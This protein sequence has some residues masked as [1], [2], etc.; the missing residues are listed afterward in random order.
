M[1]QDLIP[2]ASLPFYRSMLERSGFEADI[3]AFDAG[4]AAGDPEQAKAGLSDALLDSLA[5]I[6]DA[7]RV[8][9]AVERYRD[10]GADQPMRGRHPGHRLRRR[11]QGGRRA[12]LAS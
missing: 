7:G 4:M 6:G 2:Y 5:G 8:K 10:A 11:P 12:D 3:A 9:D 1:R